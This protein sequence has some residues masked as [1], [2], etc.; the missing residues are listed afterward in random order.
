M[1]IT[2]SLTNALS[3]LTANARSAEVV[4][5]NI[6]NALTEG[7]GRREIELSARSLAGQGAGV[8]VAGVSR[9]VD[10]YIIGERR[11]ADADLA[12]Q[13]AKAEY[14][15]RLQFLLG[16]PDDPGSLTGRISTLVTSL[17]E[18]ASRPDSNTRAD[19]A[20]RAASALASH[21]N[22]ASDEVQNLRMKADQDIARQVS[23]LN[24]GLNRVHELN[25]AIRANFSA[26]NDINTFMDQRQILIDELSAIVPLRVADR[27]QGQV[28]LYTPGGAIL[29]DGQPVQVA[30]TQV[31]VITPD[32]TLASG[33]LFG[34][35]INGLPMPAT[36]NGQ[37][38]GGSL[39]ASFEIRDILATSAQGELDAVAR[40]LIE[41]FADS[42]VDPTLP[43]GDPGLFTDGGLAFL[44]VNEIGVAGRIELNAL[45][46][47]AAGGALWR[48]RDGLGAVAPGNVGDASLLHALTD[49]LTGTRTPASGAFSAGSYTASA[50]SGELM[51]LVNA[52]LSDLLSAESFAQAERDTFKSIEL[53]N[54]V[55]SDHEMQKLLLIEQAF[56]A[57][58][59]V[60]ATAEAMIRTLL[61][62]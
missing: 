43:P 17:I 12:L 42:G 32:M 38:A 21:L 2:A 10:R 23:R 20:L 62:L 57:N 9:N 29:L 14:Q 36:G 54:G 35:T 3:G 58:A 50:L 51:S 26:G 60:I 25:V 22:R 33:A 41:R 55:D 34:L 11:L 37:M 46:D 59:R 56:A 24:A 7:Y 19:G 6:S 31:G 15:Q 27:D 48:L 30:F 16:Q 49:P 47:P 40:D 53:E 13:G 5:S 45:V 39:G 18:A 44:P 1:S 52:D 61:E 28:A 4:S 8:W